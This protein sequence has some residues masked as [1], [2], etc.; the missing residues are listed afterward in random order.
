LAS[1]KTRLA[2]DTHDIL[3]VEYGLR[4]H[5]TPAPYLPVVRVTPQGVFLSHRLCVQKDRLGLAIAK[6]LSRRPAA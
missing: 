2:A 5:L 4:T 6:V 3:L 1:R